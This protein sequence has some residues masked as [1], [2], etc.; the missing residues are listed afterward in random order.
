MGI[1]VAESR[2]EFGNPG[3][4]PAFEE[5]VTRGLVKTQLRRHVRALVNCL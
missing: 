5:A 4:R 3:E 1:A 2:G